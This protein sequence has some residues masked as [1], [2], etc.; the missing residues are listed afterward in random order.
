MQHSK[1]DFEN[2]CRI[3]AHDPLKPREMLFPLARYCFNHQH[4]NYLILRLT[5]VKTQHISAN[6][7]T[8]IIQ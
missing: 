3:G 5:V 1:W 7:I 8:G 6:N 4:M 2:L